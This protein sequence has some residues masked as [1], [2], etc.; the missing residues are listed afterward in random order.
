VTQTGL[1]GASSPRGSARTVGF[2]TDNT[3]IGGPTD[4]GATLR[5]VI[6]SDAHGPEIHQVTVT[7]KG[8]KQT[9]IPFKDPA[10]THSVTVTRTD[11]GKP[12]PVF[13]EVS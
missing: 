1:S 3:L 11:T 7:S 13:A 9:V 2:F 8:S 6:W 5:V 4:P 10:S 12:Y